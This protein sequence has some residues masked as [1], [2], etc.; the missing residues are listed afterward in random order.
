[1]EAVLPL[2]QMTTAEKLR[3]MEAI[4]ADLT[5]NADSFDSPAW[6]ADVLRER[7]QRIAEGKETF[8]DWDEAKRQLRERLL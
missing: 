3:A 2:D 8:I 1:M 4:W 7:E 6:H 5:R